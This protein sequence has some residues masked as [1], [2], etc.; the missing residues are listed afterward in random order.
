MFFGP[1]PSVEAVLFF[2]H[3]RF[4]CVP[5]I[6]VQDLSFSP[7]P[8]G[9]SRSACSLFPESFLNVIVLLPLSV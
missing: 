6:L 1:S 5:V 4:E 7:Y 3:S 9:R 2:S 8:F